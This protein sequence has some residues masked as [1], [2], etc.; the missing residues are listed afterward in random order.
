MKNLFTDKVNM[1][2]Y[3]LFSATIASLMLA[4]L[5]LHLLL[6]KMK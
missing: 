3:G 2:F 6:L 1:I 5:L 4:H